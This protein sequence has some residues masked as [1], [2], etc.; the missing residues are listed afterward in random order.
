MN[1]DQPGDREIKEAAARLLGV[2]LT[3]DA[4]ARDT[5]NLEA[6]ALGRIARALARSIHDPGFERSDRDRKFVKEVNHTARTYL[7]RSRRVQKGTPRAPA[8][9]VTRPRASSATL[10]AEVLRHIER[11]QASGSDLVTAALSTTR[12]LAQRRLTLPG[13]P[14]Q[15]APAQATRTLDRR[16][17]SA[18]V[19]RILERVKTKLDG[20]KKKRADEPKDAVRAI[21]RGWAAAVGTREL[22]DPFGADRVKASRDYHNKKK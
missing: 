2:A 20:M 16:A 19:D 3:L 21:W 10:A 12:W 8:A 18:L 1:A 6:E 13:M 7:E 14:R 4:V 22:P 17:R 9:V 11:S 5:G 15:S